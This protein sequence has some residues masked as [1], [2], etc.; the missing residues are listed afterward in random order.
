MDFSPTLLEVELGYLVPPG[1]RVSAP[2]AIDRTGIRVGVSQGGTSHAVLTHEMKNAT[3]VPVPTVK[4]AID[5]L[6]AGTLDVFA[7]NK[8][9][10][11][12]IA[13]AVPG[14]KILEGRWGLEHFAFAI[15]KGRENGAA[16]LRAFAEDVKN[17]GAL[18]RAGLRGEA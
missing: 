14:A 13:D 3:V 18:R 16:Y 11:F 12:E 7:T 6:K 9:I 2:A 8:G 1:S 5:M 17:S 4:A 15:P 10:L